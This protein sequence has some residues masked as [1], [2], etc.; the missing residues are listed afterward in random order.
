MDEMPYG[1][2]VARRAWLGPGDVINTMPVEEL[3]KF[4]QNR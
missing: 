1:V 4:L 3:M 2:S